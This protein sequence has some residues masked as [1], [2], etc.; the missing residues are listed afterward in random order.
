[1]K[2]PIRFPILLLLL[3]AL[4]AALWGG[5]ARL[6]WSLPSL[7]LSLPAVHGPLMVSGFLGSLVALERAVALGKRPAF[8]A[9]LLGVSGAVALLLGAPDPF[10]PLLV[11]L[12]SLG[13]VAIAGY[14]VRRQP[15]AYTAVIALGAFCWSTGNGLW[16]FGRSV[17]EVVSWWLS[18]LILTIVGE[19][20]ELSRVSRLTSHSTRL[21]SMAVGLVGAGL[22]FTLF[23]LAAGVR[24][25]GFGLLALALWLLRY[26]IAR[27]TVHGQ[28]LVRYIAA[29]LLAGYLW[30]ATGGLLAVRYGGVTAGMSYDAWLHALS[31]GFV[32]SMIF[33]HAPIIL[34]ALSGLSLTFHPLLYGPPLLMHLALLA[35]IGG[36]VTGWLDGRR[37]GGLI[38]ALAIL[39]FLAQMAALV[40]LTRA[41]N[42][43]ARARA[44]GESNMS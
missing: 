44:S 42:R 5:L 18:F 36:D 41:R 2:G 17:P 26:D 1:M 32:F 19:R 12:S 3:T 34:P 11:T 30:L 27:R 21:F 6:P 35:R 14:M 9:P 39:W 25:T 4:L 40:L 23:D 7:R 37:W 29:N 28:G 43:P 22:V 15:A 8:L 13:M 24:L 20:L 10:G 38:N 31:L 33:A 16:L